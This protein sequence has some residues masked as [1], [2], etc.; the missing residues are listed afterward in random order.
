MLSDDFPFLLP[1]NLD[2]DLPE[3]LHRLAEDVS[4]LCAGAEPNK[5]DLAHAPL[6]A[7]WRVALTPVGLRLVG[8]V[9]SHPHA[10]NSRTRIT[11]QLW[12]ADAGG[13]WVRTLSRFYRLGAPFAEEAADRDGHRAP[14]IT[15]S[16]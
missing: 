5:S 13:R 14:D 1:C 3:R 11:S 12:V 10:P 16:L 8:R 4:Q 7:D 9:A 2:H 15:D 6:I